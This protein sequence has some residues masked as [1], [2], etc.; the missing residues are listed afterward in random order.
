[1]SR[2]TLYI[3]SDPS[4]VPGPTL[5]VVGGGEIGPTVPRFDDSVFCTA[6]SYPVACDRHRRQYLY[7]VIG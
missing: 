4:T 3:D 1:M 2:V 5:G 7:L 6:P